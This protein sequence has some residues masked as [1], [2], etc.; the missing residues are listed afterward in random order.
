M[1]TLREKMRARG[2][3][4]LAHS[5]IINLG[6]TVVSTLSLMTLATATAL[7]IV[8]Q[9][10]RTEGNTSVGN[11]SGRSV[12]LKGVSAES[13][14]KVI[15]SGIM[16]HVQNSKTTSNSLVKKILVEPYSPSTGHQEGSI[17]KKQD[18]FFFTTF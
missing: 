14:Q 3:L 4:L 1:A 18:N 5:P 11:T 7:S 15:G 2:E 12:N 10:S 16:G 8:L 17:T 9:T 6:C 13:L